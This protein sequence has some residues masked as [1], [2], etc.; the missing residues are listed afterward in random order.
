M[1][2]FSIPLHEAE[3]MC[4]PASGNTVVG[5]QGNDLVDQRP[6]HIRIF[7]CE[8]CASCR[9]AYG[10]SA[11]CARKYCTF[12]QHSVYIRRMFPECVIAKLIGHNDN[13]IRLIVHHYLPSSMAAMVILPSS[14]S[15]D[16]ALPN[17]ESTSLSD[18]NTAPRTLHSFSGHRI[19]PGRNA[20]SAAGTESC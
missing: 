20:R 6:V 1:P 18:W 15:T 10:L 2:A 7:A 12:F 4:M 3:Q 11:I 14:L 19:F 5:L 17:R 8:E 16:G 13:D 9:R